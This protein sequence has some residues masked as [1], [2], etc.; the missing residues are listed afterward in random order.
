VVLKRDEMNL[1]SR[2]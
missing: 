2:G 1:D